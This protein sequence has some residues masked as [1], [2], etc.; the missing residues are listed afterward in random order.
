[1]DNTYLG[2]VLRV[3][4]TGANTNL[5]IQKEDGN[6]FLVPNVKQ[7]V[8]DVNLLKKTMKIKVIE[9]LI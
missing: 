7:F 5:R 4:E 6:T 1:M 9:G 3:E 8:K 2:I